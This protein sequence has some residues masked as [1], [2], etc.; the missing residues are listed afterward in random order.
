M[1]QSI[2]T[3]N[4]PPDDTD[5]DISAALPTATTDT[6]AGRTAAPTTV[7]RTTQPDDAGT[8]ASTVRAD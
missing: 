1:R 5:V 4:I 8:R 3:P 2:A 6:V 7:S